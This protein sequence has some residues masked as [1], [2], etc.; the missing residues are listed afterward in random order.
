M[1]QVSRLQQRR[2][3]YWILKHLEKRIGEKEEAIV[4][5]KRRRGYQVLIPEY[6]LECEIPFTSG[7]DLKPEDLVQVVIQ[8][9][10]ARKDILNV[11]VG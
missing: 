5:N 3:R 2:L 1:S 8:R 7:L 9:V 11:F 10:H 4:L 6:M